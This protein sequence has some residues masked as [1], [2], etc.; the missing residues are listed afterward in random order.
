MVF[1]YVDESYDCPIPHVDKIYLK[2]IE[3]S[4][5]GKIWYSC[6]DGDGQE[7]WFEN[8]AIGLFVFDKYEEAVAACARD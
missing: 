2:Q 3:K 7:V 4:E 5:D 8:R 1:Y 6:V